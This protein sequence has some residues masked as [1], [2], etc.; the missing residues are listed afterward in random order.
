MTKNEMAE[1]IAQ[2]FARAWGDDK[3]DDAL[4]LAHA[5][6]RVIDGA[7]YELN[8][9]NNRASKIGRHGTVGWLLGR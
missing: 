6:L 2:A 3:E 1:D 8:K 9:R 5:L 4:T 7:G